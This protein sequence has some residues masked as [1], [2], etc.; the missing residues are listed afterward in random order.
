MS[1]HAQ[2]LEF[3]TTIHKLFG[4][5]LMAAGLTRVIEICF[6][7]QDQP[8][9]LDSSASRAF[10][11]LPPYLLVLSG[12]TFLSATEEQMGWIN[13][14][15]MDSTTYANI[16]FSGA[17]VI[18]LVAVALVEFYERGS[19]TDLEKEGDLEQGGRRIWGIPLP[20]F[21]G[22]VFPGA[23]RSLRS[24]E[25]VSAPYESVP[26]SNRSPPDSGFGEA[27]GRVRLDSMAED[28][29]NRSV[30]DLGDEEDEGDDKYW[31][32]SEGKRT[33]TVA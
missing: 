18:Y 4:F 17:F 13:S 33:R 3:S 15:G 1:A 25:A 20:A 22:S 23:G 9:P 28:G 29:L 24:E 11:H 16:L 5:S 7:L 8:T 2:A 6:V 27:G 21:A 10:Q 30:F 32:E 12:L 26:M 19:R 14:V 31:E